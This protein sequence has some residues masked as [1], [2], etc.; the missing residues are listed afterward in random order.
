MTVVDNIKTILPK[1]ESIKEFIG[2]VGEC[3]QIDK[4][5][6]GMVMSALITMKFDDSRTMHEHVIEMTNIAARFK[7]LEMIV[8]ENFLVK[9][10]LKSKKTS[11]GNNCHFCEKS[12]HF[13][14]D[15]PKHKTEYMIHV[16]NTMQ[17]FI[18][19]EIISPNEKSVFMG[20]RV[21]V[22][23]KIV[24]TYHIILNIGHHIDLKNEI[25]PNLDFTYINN[26]VDCIEGKQTKH[27]KKKKMKVVRSDRGGDYYRR[28]DE[29]KKLDARIISGYFIGYP[30]KSKE[31][32][33]Y[34]PNHSMRIVETRNARFIEN[35]KISRST[36]PREVEVKEVEC[37][38]L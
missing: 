29:K 5:L 21:N 32:M 37:K 8:N 2:F 15:C 9:F 6:V 3:S 13:Q 34:Y 19:I 12:G 31:Y 11:K 35:R 20:N 14:Q 26:C 4:Y 17:Q 24:G 38:F 18:T 23:V 36:V 7:S 25:L 22:L 1:I 16:S 27:T 28:Y 33:F 30:K 10:I